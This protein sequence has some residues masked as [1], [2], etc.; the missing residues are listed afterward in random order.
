MDLIDFIAIVGALAWTPH[1]I[2][3][4]RNWWLKPEI[5]IITGPSPEI[6]FTSYGPI[7]NL[8]IAFTVK[9]KDIVVSGL[10]VKIKHEDG[11]EKVFEW[12]GIKQEILKTYQADGS[13]IPHRREHS[14]L[15]IKLNQQQIEERFIQLQETAFHVD[16]DPLLQK[17]IKKAAFLSKK[18]PIDPKSFVECQEM[19][20]LIEFSELSCI[21]KTGNY[22]IAIDLESPDIFSLKS[23]KYRFE[24]N[25]HEVASLEANK[26]AIKLDYINMGGA[27]EKDEKAA[28]WNWVNPKLSQIN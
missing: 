1:I 27:P 20:E 24:L 2:V 5:A 25:S 13:N 21:W 7:F 11:E 4:V 19:N 6:G 18:G 23:N 3:L 15:A 9:H 17:C 26:E 22:S 16:K 14:V 10:K 12:Q 28:I 8:N